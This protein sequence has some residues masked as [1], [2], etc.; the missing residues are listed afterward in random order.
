[1]RGDLLGERLDALRFGQAEGPQELADAL[2]RA[3]EGLGRTLLYATRG[4]L[5]APR[6]LDLGGGKH[7]ESICW[8]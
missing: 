5:Y 4:L 2:R 7:T 3:L 1:M 6:T 8:I